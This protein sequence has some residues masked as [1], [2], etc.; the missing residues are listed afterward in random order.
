MKHII[1]ILH[2]LMLAYCGFAQSSFSINS[3][4]RNNV[5]VFG[6][7]AGLD[8]STGDPV[9][10]K[11]KFQQMEGC[12]SVC[13]GNGH[14]LFYTNGTNVYNRNF[15]RMPNGLSI[16]DYFTNSTGQATI[17]LPVIGSDIRYYVFSLEELSFSNP[18]TCRLSCRVVNM[19]LDGGYGDVEASPVLFSADSLSEKMIAIPGVNH[20][21][22]LLVH[23][24]NIG[25]FLAY[26]VT[27]SGISNVPFVSVAGNQ[28][29]NNYALGLMKVSSD[30]EKIVCQNS[31]IYPLTKGGTTEIFRFN[32][33]SG[34]VFDAVVIDSTISAPYGAEFSP[35]NSKLYTSVQISNDSANIYQFD[36]SLMNVPA[37]KASKTLVKSN[38]G[39]AS[40]L[41]TGPNG[42]IYFVG[43]DDSVSTPSPLY[44]RWLD[45]ISSPNLP[46]TSCNYVA[47]SVRCVDST[48]ML[49]GLPNTFV[50]VDTTA[51]GLTDLQG[52]SKFML[53][54]NPATTE[55]TVS[56]ERKITELTILTI[57]GEEIV[58]SLCSAR[59]VNVNISS[60]P[61]NIYFVRIN[62]TEIRRFIKM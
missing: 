43:Q 19:A 59:I 44:F 26:E 40:D 27:S 29:S 12:A 18:F 17:I 5:W 48:G 31:Y 7:N 56:G 47:H 57:T 61:A 38:Y 50:T 20:N 53:H 51:T 28:F 8:F 14:L 2:L 4:K 45:C 11:T 16:S 1:I 6:K 22:W 46:G 41:K 25:E 21:I 23:R 60:L 32:R 9:P 39:I 36:V 42:K 3:S 54:P 13:D 37:I 35:D 62:G 52:T 33:S 49:F 10:I 30:G 24:K 58:H 15:Q 34:M 55:L